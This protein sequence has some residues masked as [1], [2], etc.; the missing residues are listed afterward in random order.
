MKDGG[1]VTGKL[2]SVR[3][4]SATPKRRDAFIN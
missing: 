1:Q 4:G 2:T 3:L